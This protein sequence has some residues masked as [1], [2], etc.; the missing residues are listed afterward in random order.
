MIC[1]R[2]PEYIRRVRLDFAKAYTEAEI[3][4]ALQ[5]WTAP[6]QR[7]DDAVHACPIIQLD[8]VVERLV[9]FRR[10]AEE[11]RMEA[12]DAKRVLAIFENAA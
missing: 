9:A 7:I 1:L 12:R 8:I 4:A 6:L 3:E 11:A 2:L 10:L 5:K